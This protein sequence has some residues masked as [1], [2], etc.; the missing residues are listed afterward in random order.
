MTCTR[1]EVNDSDSSDEKEFERSVF[2]YDKALLDA[3]DTKQKSRNESAPTTSCTVSN[4]D[5]QQPS[6]SSGGSVIDEGIASLTTLRFDRAKFILF[7]LLRKIN[8]DDLSIYIHENK[9]TRIEHT[10]FTRIYHESL[11]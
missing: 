2:F 9:I 10:K 5:D 6:C 4:A 8:V 1:L 11:K 7:H 3:S